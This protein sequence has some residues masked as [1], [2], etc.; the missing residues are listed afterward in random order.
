MRVCIVGNS[1]LAALKLAVTQGRIS[2]PEHDI[3]FW[4]ARGKRFSSIRLKSGRLVPGGDPAVAEEVLRVS[5]QRHQEI[6]PHNFDLIAFYAG[7]LPLPAFV[8]DIAAL[9]RPDG[10]PFSGSC[11]RAAARQWLE[12][13][14]AFA[15]A[16]QIVASGSTRVLLVPQPYWSANDTVA[17]PPALPSGLLDLIEQTLAATAREHG[18]EILFQPRHTLDDSGFTR[19]EFSVNSVRLTESLDQKHDDVDNKHMNAE[20]GALALTGILG[21]PATA[22]VA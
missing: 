14:R 19:A 1:H 17:K 7:S 20:F 15:W 13:R 21:S 10:L 8:Y 6:D 16:R 18:L 9:C 2:F 4:G 5:D 11:L 12:E 3:V 22:K